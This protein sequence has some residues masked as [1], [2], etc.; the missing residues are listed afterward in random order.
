MT[1]KLKFRNLII[2]TIILLALAGAIIFFINKQKI[3]RANEAKSGC[4]EIIVIFNKQTDLLRMENI[5]RL[6]QGEIV[7]D[8]SKINERE[9]LSDYFGQFTIRAKGRCSE[10]SVS[11]VIE[12]LKKYPEV[13]Q[14]MPN[15]FNNIR[16]PSSN[17]PGA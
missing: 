11:K 5:I 6:A 14:A 15:I 1:G 12:N 16:P 7:K 8:W 10:D 13:K 2:I 9:Y 4:N 3:I 17:P